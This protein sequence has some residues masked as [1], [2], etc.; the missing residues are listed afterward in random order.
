MTDI[1][2]FEPVDRRRDL[3]I[4][5]FKREYF[6]PG[7][8]VVIEDA[9]DQWKARSSWTFDFFRFRFGKDIIETYRYEQGNYQPDHINRIPL[10]AF[11]D[12]I[13]A[14]DWDTYPYYMRDN[15]GFLLQHK[16]LLTDFSE[17]KYFFD[18]F[19]LLPT[20]MRRPGLRIFIGPKGAV[21]NLHQDIWGTH[22]WMA[23]LAGRKRWVM[24]SPDQMGLLYNNC[25]QV[26]PDNPD[27][28]RFPMFANAKGLDCT[29]GPG[30]LIFLP[31]K[32]VHW[33]L[34]LDPTISLSYNF[35]GPGCFRVCLAGY[36]RDFLG[37]RIKRTLLRRAA[38]ATGSGNA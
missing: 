33:V 9:I 8:P 10:G 34:S 6:Y 20:S 36:M 22:F 3:S 17:P 13:I 24:F 30:D 15:C 25:W 16:E 1:I 5:E 29:I 31:S 38:S 19:R 37:A 2:H 21:T 14:N 32:W 4:K 27:L 28:D 35:M 23:Q 18:W 7:R 26:R 11:I 12:E